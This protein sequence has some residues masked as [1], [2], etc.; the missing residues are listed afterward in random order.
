ML[1]DRPYGPDTASEPFALAVMTE[2]AAGL[3]GD[4]GARRRLV[5]LIDRWAGAG[6]LTQLER[7]S[8]NTYYALDRTLL[9][10]LVA[11]ALVRDTAELDALAPPAD[12][13]LARAAG[14]A[15][16]PGAPD[17]GARR[18]LGAQQSPLSP[19]QRRHRLGRAQRRRYAFRRGAAA[20]LDALRD[21]R[22]DGSLPLETGAAPAPC[23]TSG[24]PSPRSW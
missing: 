22:A 13:E 7:P 9:P 5:D 4:A 3:A 19:G 21:M 12:P 10:T 20:Y 16:R 24:M 2:A 17:P 11:F 15:A 14:P 1:R 18:D 23:R 6:A 8:A